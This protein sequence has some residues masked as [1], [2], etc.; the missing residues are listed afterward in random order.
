M[1]GPRSLVYRITSSRAVRRVP[2]D[3]GV[4]LFLTAILFL[5]GVLESLEYIESLAPLVIAIRENTIILAAFVA[6][7][8][9]LHRTDVSDIHPHLFDENSRAS[10]DSEFIGENYTF[11]LELEVQFVNRGGRDGELNEIRIVDTDT[12]I[13][14]EDPI[15]I[16]LK[17]SMDD[18]TI[19]ALS[20]E[21]ATVTLIYTLGDMTD[22][23]ELIDE[24]ESTMDFELE[25]EFSDSESSNLTSRYRR[26]ETLQL[27]AETIEVIQESVEV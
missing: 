16:E 7:F 2:F 25:F 21:L 12:S 17:Y 20:D 15:D 18:A 24:S 1:K 3:L 13:P 11:E 8:L 10:I 4:L 14:Y 5:L 23:D 19:S 27:A 22:L 26:Y 6:I 9:Y